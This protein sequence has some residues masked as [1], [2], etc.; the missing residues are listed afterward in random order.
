LSGSEH[1]RSIPIYKDGVWKKC[2]SS[3]DFKVGN[4]IRVA[5]KIHGISFLNRKDGDIKWSGK[6]RLQHRI[7]GIIVT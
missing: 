4:R 6:C 1:M 2:F 5:V 7:L 3:D